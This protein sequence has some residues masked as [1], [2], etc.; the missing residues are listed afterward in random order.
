MKLLVT[1]GIQAKERHTRPGIQ[2][3]ERH[4]RPGASARKRHTRPVLLILATLFLLTPQTPAQQNPV[5]HLDAGNPET[6][7]TSPGT[8]L[9]TRWNDLSGNAHNATTLNGSVEYPG[10]GEFATGKT[11]LAFHGS[12]DLMELFSASASDAI[13][14]FTGEASGNS[15]FAILIAFKVDEII[16]TWN[17]LV[18]NTSAAQDK[19]HL[20]I[21]YSES[22]TFQ[23]YMGSGVHIQSGTLNQGESVVFAVS[24]NAGSGDFEFWNSNDRT[25]RTDN[26]PAADFSNNNPIFLGGLSNP[27]GNRYF[28]GLVGEVMIFDAALTTEDLVAYGDSMRIRWTIENVETDPPSPDPAAFKIP[29]H[30]VA[31]SLVTMTA[32]AGS[33]L[34]E[35]VKYRFTEVTG[36]PGGSTSGWTRYATFRDGD[37]Q[38]DTEYRYTVQMKDALGN[39]GTASDTLSATTPAYQA[40]GQTNELENRVFYGYQGWHFAPGDGRTQSNNWVHWFEQNIDDAEHIHGDF[41]PELEE[42]DPENLYPTQM[43]YP[44]GD[45]ARVYSSHDYSTIDLHVK[46]MKEYGI[47]GCVV[48]RFTNA[49]D[50][51]SKL[52]QG[53]KKLRDIMTACEKYGVKFW[54]MHDAGGGDPGEYD[55]ITNDW[56]H[57]VE[58]LDILQS[59]AYTYQ[60]GL[61][62]YGLWGIGVNSRDWTPETVNAIADFYQSGPAEYR[63]YIMG[64]I[65]SGN[66]RGLTDW[67]PVYE[68]L[69]MVSPWRTI[70]YQGGPG[71]QSNIDRMHADK[72]WCDAR[73]VDYNPVISPGASTLHLRDSDDMYNWTPREG[74]HFIWNQLYEVRKMGSPFVYVAMFDEVDEGTAM[75]KMAETPAELPVGAQQ[76]PLNIDGYRLPDDWYLR[77]GREMQ[78]MMDGSLP[79]TEE[80]P[81]T[82]HQYTLTPV[83]ANEAVNIAPTTGLSWSGFPEADSV[84]LYLREGSPWFTAGDRV[85]VLTEPAYTTGTPLKDGTTY[86]WRVDVAVDGYTVKGTPWSFTTAGASGIESPGAGEPYIWPVPANEQLHVSPGTTGG[87]YTI[88]R[89]DGVQVASGNLDEKIIDVGSM[90]P[91]L[92]IFKTAE[93]TMR[94]I[95]K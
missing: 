4:T 67:L 34:N 41:W 48:Q 8:N 24:Y 23:L 39:T 28:E 11:G 27:P 35:P 93:K 7:I 62:V 70:F 45:T 77:V 52:E 42:Y 51:P 87:R 14:D 92:Y 6:V 72:D 20:G 37:L 38:P 13:L 74:G 73:G 12:D 44:N 59:P 71:N 30:G 33:D 56:I 57:L 17:D 5:M 19:A 64:G 21:R 1:P 29:P 46:W 47:G 88:Y 63:A 55:R 79:L 95:K 43:V 81:I 68:R 16:S 22:G 54:L 82:P 69:D 83:P 18:G 85:G 50:S 60:D 26:T 61:P 65:S 84:Y 15:G 76:V 32:E 94:F 91:G 89:S 58:D 80:I 90:Q 53:D 78:K 9:V 25:I 66:W 10:A 49:I 3:K 31:H 86:Y 40:P 36:N 75:Y 2:A